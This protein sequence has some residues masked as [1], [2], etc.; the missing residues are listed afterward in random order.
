MVPA[1]V[2][3]LGLHSLKAGEDWLLA[4][5]YVGKAA[6]SPTWAELVRLAEQ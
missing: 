6:L 2:L 5:Q 1:E 4:R 3:V